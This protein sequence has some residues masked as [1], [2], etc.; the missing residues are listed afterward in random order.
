MQVEGIEYNT[1]ILISS[2]PSPPG[3]TTWQI[4]SRTGENIELTTATPEMLAKHQTTIPQ[5]VP[6]TKNENL[7]TKYETTKAIHVTPATHH[8]KAETNHQHNFK[9]ENISET[10]YETFD[11][12]ISS[13][14]STLLDLLSSNENTTPFN[15]VAD[16][17]KNKD[18]N[19]MIDKQ[20]NLEDDDEETR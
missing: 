13:E 12:V 15:E 16:K 20:E 2:S 6:A 4:V 17:T 7:E 3:L 8:K 19:Y 10:S 11:A 5:K 14:T 9:I 1:N 18:K